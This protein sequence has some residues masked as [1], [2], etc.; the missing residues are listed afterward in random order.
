MK[1]LFKDLLRSDDPALGMFIHLPSEVI[2]EVIGKTGYDYLILDDEHGQMCEAEQVSLLRECDG[3]DIATLIRV[4][5]I[6]EVSIKHALD[7]GASGIVVPGISSAEDARKAV[8]YARFGPVGKRGN[9]AN[10]RA[11]DHGLTRGNKEYFE[12]A[13]ENIAVVLLVEGAEGVKNIEE[14]AKVPGYDA[15]F[16]GP[17]DLSVS[18]GI[19][20]DL[21]NPLIEEAM[22]RVAKAVRENGKYLGRYG[23][24]LEQA[25]RWKKGDADFYI[26]G[27]I[28]IDIYNASK[29]NSD[30]IKE[31]LNSGT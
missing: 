19:P 20:G 5:G 7:M 9:C 18:L 31:K 22:E 29:N 16:L 14:I 4:P 8:D 15:I 21:E 26:Y 12:W 28:E 2:V 13:N 3:V 6:D 10:T 27:H 25:L 24:T 17:V 11:N 30:A 23:F 1:K